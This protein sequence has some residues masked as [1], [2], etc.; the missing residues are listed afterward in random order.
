MII[1]ILALIAAGA[2]IAFRAT[3]RFSFGAWTVVAFMI[4][5]WVGTSAGIFY[6]AITAMTILCLA[7]A[8]VRGLRWSVVDS[9]VAVFIVLVLGSCVLGDVVV[10]H[11]IIVLLDWLLPYVWGRLI[12]SI[13]EIEF[14]LK[15]VAVL[16]V[17]A[18]V[19]AIVEFGTGINVFV[20]TSWQNGGYSLWGPLQYRGG[21][22]RAEGAFG[23]SIALGASLSIGSVFALAS[24]MPQ[25]VKLTAISIIG[26]A[27]VV[28]LSRIGLVGF[29]L[30]LV[31][32][33]LFL[34][35]ELRTG[36]RLVAGLVLIVGTGVAA[37]FLSD[38]LSS[39]GNE[40]T[41]SAQYR[42]DL[43]SLV[44]EM[45]ALGRSDVYS[46]L[47][48][49]TVAVGEFQSIDS[50]LILTGLR[51]G[52]V[53]L[54]LVV[55]L[56]VAGSITVIRRRANAPM[57]A[58]VAQIPTLATVALI[59]QLPYLLWF[60]AGLGVRMY[61]LSKESVRGTGRLTGVKAWGLE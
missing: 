16:T 56:L 35:T 31:L 26:A 36:H 27:I 11:L 22:L 33:L 3:P 59:T 38:T 20:V 43:I 51:F 30:G 15:T 55:A 52:Y 10:G 32:S 21:F 8:S 9:V 58:V 28:T 46:F 39:A 60:S 61:M 40:A 23:H 37:P 54:L 4:P 53:P 49:G 25:A 5:I 1:A 29:A 45:S 12:L 14:V 6:S 41:G 57:I 18:A 44:P 13:V 47:A 50:A 2:A 34:P 7:S 24:R 42:V 19:L 48:D 17:V